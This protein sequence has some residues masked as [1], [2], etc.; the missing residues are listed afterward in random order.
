LDGWQRNPKFR[1]V[2]ARFEGHPDPDIL[3]Q[4]E[5]INGIARLAERG[6]ILEFLVRAAHL[7]HILALYER[8][9]RLKAIIEHM[10]K[11][12]FVGGTDRAEWRSLM[13][14]LALNT[15]VACKLSLSPRV[16][17]LGDLLKEPRCGW[18]VEMI[19]PF[20]SSLV[21]WFGTSRLMWGSDWPV[22]LLVA[23]YQD[24]LHA[25]RTA[26]G[27]LEP[28]EEEKLFRSSGMN[29]YQLESAAGA[30]ADFRG[31]KVASR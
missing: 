2:R 8:I 14:A 30:E 25:M 16:E 23:N 12:D 26:L 5:V 4:P 19:K 13:Q 27:K 6:L 21:E 7:K 11:P 20:V 10:A 22:A 1:G 28:Q 29:F 31:H 15:P 3:A 9:P 18:P 17:E 24:T